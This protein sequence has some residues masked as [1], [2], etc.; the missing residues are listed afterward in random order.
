[1]LDAR[2][3]FDPEVATAT[4]RGFLASV[5]PREFPS[6]LAAP[7]PSGKQGEC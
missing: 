6:R 3:P 1:M 4:C 7:A 5:F 2:T